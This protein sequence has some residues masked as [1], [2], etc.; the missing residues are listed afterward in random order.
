MTQTLKDIGRM[1]KEMRRAAKLTQ[2]QLAD[3]VGVSRVTICNWEGAKYDIQIERLCQ[4]AKVCG[5]EISLKIEPLDAV[6]DG[7]S[8]DQP[9]G[10]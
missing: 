9:Q 4:V 6:K 2:T 10:E 5:Y 1:V 7:E 8:H 3:L